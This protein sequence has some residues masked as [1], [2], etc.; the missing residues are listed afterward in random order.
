MKFV[1]HS[2]QLNV[3][4]IVFCNRTIHISVE[5]DLFPVPCH[6]DG[7]RQEQLWP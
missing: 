7:Y 2:L 1:I 3:L 6:T 5:S 4:F